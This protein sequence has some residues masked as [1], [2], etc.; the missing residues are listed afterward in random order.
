[1]IILFF[2]VTRIRNFYEIPY[3][4]QCHSGL[5]C[6][7]HRLTSASL[8]GLTLP[9][10]SEGVICN[11]VSSSPSSVLPVGR[12]V[13]NRPCDSFPEGLPWRLLRH[14][15]PRNDS[16]VEIASSL[17]NLTALVIA[18][19]RRSNLTGLGSYPIDCF[20][21]LCYTRNDTYTTLHHRQTFK[22]HL[23]AQPVFRKLVLVVCRLLKT[24]C[25]YVESHKQ[26]GQHQR[27]SRINILP[28]V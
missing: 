23:Q 18:S 16:V 7:A 6:Y 4:L 15:V 26:I 20:V 14:C 25:N 24:N 13:A 1:M 2:I 3:N 9:Q 10:K 22:A 8:H 28:S 11:E 19:R 12:Q 21:P 5:R 27:L 17:L